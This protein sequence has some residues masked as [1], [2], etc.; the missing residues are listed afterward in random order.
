MKQRWEWKDIRPWLMHW[1]D[2]CLP[3]VTRF[4]NTLLVQGVIVSGVSRL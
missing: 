1:R 4:D 3:L 2:R